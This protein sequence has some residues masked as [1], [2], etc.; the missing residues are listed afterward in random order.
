MAK[1]D[2]SMKRSFQAEQVFEKK[3]GNIFVVGAVA[4]GVV[5]IIARRKGPK[6]TVTEA[7]FTLNEKELE[8][9][10]ATLRAAKGK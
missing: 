10:L 3:L 4:D 8:M 7:T 6:A 9:C 5:Y 1:I 2:L